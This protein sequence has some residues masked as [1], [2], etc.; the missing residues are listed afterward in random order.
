[1]YQQQNYEFY[2]T[3][4]SKKGP[5]G[6]NTLVIALGCVCSCY[7]IYLYLSS[8]ITYLTTLLSLLFMFK[9]KLLK[10]KIELFTV[11]YFTKKARFP[12]SE[13]CC[14]LPAERQLGNRF[15]Q[16]KPPQSKPVQPPRTLWLLEGEVLLR[17]RVR[18][19][20]VTKEIGCWQISSGINLNQR[21]FLFFCFVVF[22]CFR[23]LK[24]AHILQVGWI[25]YVVVVVIS[26]LLALN[27]WGSILFRR[28]RTVDRGTF[29][30]GSSFGAEENCPRE[31]R[32]WLKC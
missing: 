5:W 6:E 25:L 3:N 24:F 16:K 1:M 28:D 10:S 15:S 2:S 12:W 11:D 7:C 8:T 21:S 18:P 22:F 19:E 31:S 23:V 20:P 29:P 30:P 32:A 14:N 17:A 27:R 9:S 4:K 26:S 13:N